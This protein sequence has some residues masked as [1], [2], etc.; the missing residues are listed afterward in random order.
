[1]ILGGSLGARTLNDSVIAFLEE[2]GHQSVQVIWQCGSYYEDRLKTELESRIPSNVKMSAFVK[3][4]DYAYAAADVIISRAG[5]GTIS[6]LCVIG[7]PTILV[8]SPNVAEDHQ[9][10]NALAL[11]GRQAAVLVKDS[12]AVEKLLPTALK[13]LGNEQEAAMLGDN[14]KKLALPDA[15]ITIA[16]EVYK[17][18]NKIK[19]GYESG[20]Y[21]TSLSYRDRRYWDEWLSTVF[22]APRLCRYGV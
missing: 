21:K 13:L 14:I 3:R 2:L 20:R 5:A 17:L 15:D 6:E 18:A 11:V 7:K 16:K 1:M 4:M 10:K 8:P 9:T 12:E 19:R 22:Q